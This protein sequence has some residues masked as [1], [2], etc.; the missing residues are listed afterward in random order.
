MM[1]L[2]DRDQSMLEWLDVVRIADLE[3][4]R[5]A[6]AALQTDTFP[7]GPVSMRKAQQWTARMHRV[8]LV[9]RD[10]PGYIGGSVV[11]ATYAAL[12]KSA[13]NLHLQTQRHELSVARTA[14]RFMARGYLW[15]RDRI[16]LGSRDHQA[17]GVA[18][19]NG[20]RELV[21][22]ELTAKSP[23]RYK[24]I[25]NDH[26]DR[27]EAE[28]A[29]VVYLC[30]PWAATVAAREAKRILFRD[31]RD[32]VVFFPVLNVHGDWIGPDDAP[33]TNGAGEGSTAP[34]TGS[35]PVPELFERNFR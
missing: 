14:A 28:V 34:A 20:R 30:T 35:G 27:L 18:I 22:V 1:R 15:E 2:M 23:G 8:G 17:D 32:R 7:T 29:R 21:E 31:V 4:V 26:S 19:R 25:H 6:L 12:G 24:L 11:W 3:A 33:W 10:R 16:A 13:P 9:G 5:W